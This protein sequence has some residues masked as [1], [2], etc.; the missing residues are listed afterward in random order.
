VRAYKR[1]DHEVAGFPDRVVGTVE[2]TEVEVEMG[3][4][5]GG[6]E[7]VKGVSVRMERGEREGMMGGKGWGKRIEVRRGGSEER[8]VLGEWGGEMVRGWK[9]GGEVGGEGEGGGVGDED[10]VVTEDGAEVGEEGGVEEVGP[11]EGVW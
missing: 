11:G 5:K 4:E 10:G 7:M 9:G 3:R 2:M 1:Q 6:K 8:G